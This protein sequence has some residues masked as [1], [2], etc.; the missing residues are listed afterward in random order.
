MKTKLQFA[1]IVFAT[2][3]F[4][5]VKS[6]ND[7]KAAVAGILQ[8]TTTVDGILTKMQTEIDKDQHN[9][10]EQQ[11]HPLQNSVS[12]MQDKASTLPKEYNDALT[13]KISNM[14]TS[15]DAFEKMVHKSKV[16]DNDKE[17]RS[18][19]NELKRNLA[20]IKTSANFVTGELNKPAPTT[21]NTTTPA[22]PPTTSS[23]SSNDPNVTAIIQEK[24]NIGADIDA[25]KTAMTQN[26]FTTVAAFAEKAANSAN[27][28]S[29][30]AQMYLKGEQKD[31]I[32]TFAKELNE[33]AL[34]LHEKAHKGSPEHHEIHEALSSVESKFSTL[35]LVIATLK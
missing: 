24:Y 1:I 8:E 11:I 14:K 26:G 2:F 10:L 23:T 32:K 33:L 4:L 22:T 13:N 6:Q 29:D 5:S 15:A 18:S 3:L 12:A 9:L 7:P 27:K 21:T 17:L 31:N 19:F 25:M 16:A 28:I 35:S 20:S 34:T 30:M